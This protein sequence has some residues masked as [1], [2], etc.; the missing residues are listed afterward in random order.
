M[1][2]SDK[3]RRVLS[4]TL[5]VA[6]AAAVGVNW[7]YARL[8]QSTDQSPP[9]SLGDSLLV[10]G[11]AQIDAPQDE[12][13][14]DAAASVAAMQQFFSEAQLKKTQ[15]R[16]AVKDAIETALDSEKLDAAAQ[17]KVLSLLSDL[18]SVCMAESNCETLIAAKVGGACVVVLQDGEAWVVV[19]S[20]RV[21]E[22]S[23]LQIA[24][25][26]EQIAGV[27]AENLTITE[28]K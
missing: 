23:S 19:E 28:A 4:A 5:I 20:G 10:A 24:E 9:A 12:P 7:Y 27:G 13:G 25:I 2:S 1:K 26:V 16:D 8:P 21:N 3:K 17:Q 15:S 22:T 11:T 6:L 14:D 18:D